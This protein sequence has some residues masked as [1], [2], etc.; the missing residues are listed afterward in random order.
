MPTRNVSAIPATRRASTQRQAR[1]SIPV[2]TMD[3]VHGRCS[4]RKEQPATQRAATMR[5]AYP[6]WRTTR[7]RW[8]ISRPMDPELVWIRLTV[9]SSTRDIRARRSDQGTQD[10]EKNRDGHARD[11]RYSQVGPPVVVDI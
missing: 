4:V 1:T 7:P 2:R 5:P 11:A 8:W 9:F 6:S 10:V 3:A